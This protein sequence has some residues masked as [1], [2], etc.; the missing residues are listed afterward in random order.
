MVKIIGKVLGTESEWGKLFSSFL[1]RR[2]PNRSTWSGNVALHK[3]LAGQGP[4]S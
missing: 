1:M 2:L 4:E 3:S